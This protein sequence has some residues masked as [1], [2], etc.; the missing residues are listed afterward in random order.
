MKLKNENFE[1]LQFEA[2]SLLKKFFKIENID[3]SRVR[4]TPMLPEKIRN[5]EY[6]TP[7]SGVS[8]DHPVEK[9]RSDATFVL[10]KQ[11]EFEEPQ[12]MDIFGEH[13]GG[14]IVVNLV[15]TDVNKFSLQDSIN[16][17]LYH[18]LVHAMDPNL[19]IGDDKRI[20][21]GVEI[22]RSAYNK[23]LQQGMNP[24]E[25]KLLAKKKRSEVAQS[26]SEKDVNLTDKEYFN[27]KIELTAHVNQIIFELERIRKYNPDLIDS[28]IASRDFDQILD[29]IYDW[30]TMAKHLSPK[31]LKNLKRTI[32]NTMISKSMSNIGDM[33][34]RNFF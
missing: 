5:G 4:I 32:I 22:E 24:E 20:Q 14:Y 16:S 28:A 27:K 25:A 19:E 30:Q 33:K 21:R 23:A 8:V 29:R 1:R 11:F 34:L 12:K 3:D 26:Q 31:N 9:G 2:M 6:K 10:I 7:H 13:Q 17:L 18:E 15:G